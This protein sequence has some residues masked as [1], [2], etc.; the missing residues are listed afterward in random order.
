MELAHP[1]AS[2]CLLCTGLPSGTVV[3]NLPANAGDTKAVGSIPGSGRFPRRQWQPTPVFLPGR[4]QGQRS[5]AMELQ[6]VGSLSLFQGDFLAQEL[7]QGLSFIAGRF[8]TR[9][10]EYYYLRILLPREPYRS[11]ELL[12]QSGFFHITE[13]ALH[14]KRT[15]VY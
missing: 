5:L 6:Q 8:F 9:L 1:R 12:F 3:K 15:K 10:K 2:K 14:R 7:N 11:S 4:F 13:E